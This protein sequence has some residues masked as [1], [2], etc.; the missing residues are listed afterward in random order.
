MNELESLKKKII[1]REISIEE[2]QW[3]LVKFLNSEDYAIDDRIDW[4]KVER[5]I[6]SFDNEIEGIIYCSDEESK[7]SGVL[8]IIEKAR[9]FINANKRVPLEKVSF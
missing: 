3:N 7:V 4:N 8:E 1:E 5:E 9:C 2:V 6:K